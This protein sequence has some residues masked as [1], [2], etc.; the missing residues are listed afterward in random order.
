MRQTLSLQGHQYSI[1]HNTEKILLYYF[2]D[3]LI[4]LFE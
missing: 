3:E 1:T 4:K 2:N